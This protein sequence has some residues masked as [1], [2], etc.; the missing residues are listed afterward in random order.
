M[1]NIQ[2]SLFV[3]METILKEIK[4]SCTF[5]NTEEVNLTLENSFFKSF[6]HYLRRQLESD[7]HKVSAVTK[8]FISDLGDLRKLLDLLLQTDAVDFYCYLLLLKSNLSINNSAPNS[9]S[10]STSS[11]PTY[12]NSSSTSSSHTLESSSSSLWLSTHA[13]DVLFQNARERVYTLTPIV[14]K[15]LPS[16]SYASFVK[17]KLQLSHV[18]QPTFEIPPKWKMLQ[19]IL[20]ELNKSLRPK[21]SMERPE[22]SSNVETMSQ[23]GLRVLV[24]VKD[25]KVAHQ[26]QEV[27]RTPFG[28]LQSLVE[29]KYRLFISQ[30]SHEIRSKLKPLSSSSTL[31]PEDDPLSLGIPSADLLKL[32]SDKRLLLIEV[33]SFD[34]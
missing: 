21:T 6:D 31:N 7:W 13:A 12:S 25:E 33:I 9:S 32:S 22:G 30:Q 16:P 3:A 14:P 11:K 24:I 5:L 10:S 19:D 1:M 29:N 34:L 20:Q 2:N 26:V 18:F 17:D 27:I 15:A 28:K 8:Q 4:K 23:P